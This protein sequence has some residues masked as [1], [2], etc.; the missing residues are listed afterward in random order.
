M[1]KLDKI[2]NILLKHESDGFGYAIVGDSG[3]F[4]EKCVADKFKSRIGLSKFN[5]YQIVKQKYYSFG[6]RGMPTGPAIFHG[7]TATNAK[8]LLNCHPMVIDN[9]YLI[10]NGVVTDHGPAYKT[11]TTNDSEH[12]LRRFLNGIHEVEK[13][14][15]GYYAFAAI[16][17]DFKLHVVKDKIADLNIGWSEKLDSYLIGTTYEL[18]EE[19][20]KALDVDINAIDEIADDSYFVFDNNE[21]IH[22]Q[23]IKSRGHT[24]S[25]ARYAQASIGKTLTPQGYEDHYGYYERYDRSY[26]YAESVVDATKDSNETKPV[27]VFDGVKVLSDDDL[28][29]EVANYELEL[30]NLDASYDIFDEDYNQISVE[31]FHQLDHVSQQLCTIYRDDGSEVRHWSVS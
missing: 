26:P 7:R 28:E 17:Q 1:T 22:A 11:L 16:T 30:Q 3:V 27:E 24:W 10:H 12:V 9:A 5:P 15:T 20:A 8:G 29:T 21:V 19:I 13:Y 6:Q 2:G 25:E 23:E 14:L 4:G 31:Q 18:L